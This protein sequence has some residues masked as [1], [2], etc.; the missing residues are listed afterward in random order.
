MKNAEYTRDMSTDAIV[1]D[2][3]QYGVEEEKRDQQEER[4]DV[5]Y[6]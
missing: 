1:A 6:G 5:V 3:V 4:R 2:V